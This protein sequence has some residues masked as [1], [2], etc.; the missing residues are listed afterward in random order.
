M[1]GKKVLSI[2]NIRLCGL[3]KRWS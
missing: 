3:W 2:S 1:L